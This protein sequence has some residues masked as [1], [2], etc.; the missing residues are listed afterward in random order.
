MSLINTTKIKR[1]AKIL[2]SKK[3]NDAIESNLEI[4]F[5]SD[6][7]QQYH[8]ASWEFKYRYPTDYVCDFEKNKPDEFK[9][10]SEQ[11]LEK[12]VS[13]LPW[14]PA[15]NRLPKRLKKDKILPEFIIMIILSAIISLPYSIISGLIYLLRRGHARISYY[16]HKRFYRLESS[17]FGRFKNKLKRIFLYGSM[18]FVVSLIMMSLVFKIDNSFTVLC[19]SIRGKD[20]N[21]LSSSLIIIVAIILLT[22]TLASIF[23]NSVVIPTFFF[24]NKS[25]ILGDLIKDFYNIFSS[26]AVVQDDLYITTDDKKEKLV[27]KDIKGCCSLTPLHIP[28]SDEEHLSH[29][30]TKHAYVGELTWR[31]ISPF[32]YRYYC[33]AHGY[34]IPIK[35]IFKRKPIPYSLFYKGNPMMQKSKKA[36]YFTS[37]VE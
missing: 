26:Q 33:M 29:Y 37:V 15:S 31:F 25:T 13:V 18:I 6:R 16:I 34:F 21:S 23:I 2:F 14:I 22:G 27:L 24:R 5:N 35:F 10:Y 20:V 36:K 11:S 7:T 12:E 9:S 17:M 19:D 28:Y 4:D 3:N 30:Y 1:L 32:A 8:L